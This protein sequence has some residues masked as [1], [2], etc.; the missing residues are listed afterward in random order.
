MT[1]PEKREEP[2]YGIYLF[3]LY[4]HIFFPLIILK[5]LKQFYMFD[6]KLY[7]I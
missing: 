3:E 4:R 2:Y 1:C 7:E 5:V 6:P